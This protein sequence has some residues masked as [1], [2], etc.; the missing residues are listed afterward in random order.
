MVMVPPSTFAEWEE[1]VTRLT[2]HVNEAVAERDAARV[3][4]VKAQA[5]SAGRLRALNGMTEELR[6]EWCRAEDAESRI[7]ALEKELSRL[8]EQARGPLDP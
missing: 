5:E 8:K 2:K 4:L 7:A 3:E 1:N 6:R